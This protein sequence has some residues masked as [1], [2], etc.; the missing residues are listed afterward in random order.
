MIIPPF[1]CFSH[2]EKFNWKPKSCDFSTS[3]SLSADSIAHSIV[4]Q[5]KEN[6]NQFD[7][8]WSTDDL[9]R[10]PEKKRRITLDLWLDTIY[11]YKRKRKNLLDEW[12]YVSVVIEDRVVHIENEPLCYFSLCLTSHSISFNFNPQCHFSFSSWRYSQICI[13]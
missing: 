13:W 7:I 6:K 11:T 9:R 10:H 3:L 4:F 12:E 8:S 2:T 5:R 1:L